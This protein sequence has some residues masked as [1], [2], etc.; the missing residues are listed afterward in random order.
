MKKKPIDKSQPK[1]LIY[2]YTVL[3]FEEEDELD[4]LFECIPDRW[5]LDESKSRCYW[6]PRTGKPFKLRAIS[7][8]KPD[9]ITWSVYKCK[10]VS[11]GHCKFKNFSMLFLYILQMTIYSDLQR[12][13]ESC[14]RE[15]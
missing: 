5:F 14:T 10:V 1:Y 8:E 9:I 11:E 7:C 13:I 15:M 6:P 4:K 2:K 3:E 12:R